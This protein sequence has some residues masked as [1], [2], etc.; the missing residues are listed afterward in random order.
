MRVTIMATGHNGP[1]DGRPYTANVTS[2]RGAKMVATREASG[3]RC[4]ITIYDH[5]GRELAYRR[6]FDTYAGCARGGWWPWVNI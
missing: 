2:L 3:D 4:Y 6:A 5:N 1:Q